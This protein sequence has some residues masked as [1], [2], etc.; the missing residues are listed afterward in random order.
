MKILSQA[1]ISEKLIMFLSNEL[2][3][4]PSEMSKETKIAQLGADSLTL[5]K[6]LLFIEKE[7]NINIP[8]RELTKNN[9]DSIS[10]ISRCAMEYSINE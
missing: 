3:V 6:L 10:T 7:F 1:R 8:D 2:S 4:N 9:F 5:V